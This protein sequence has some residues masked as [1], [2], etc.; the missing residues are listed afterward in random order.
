MTMTSVSTKRRCDRS[1]IER[2]VTLEMVSGAAEDG[3]RARRFRG[4][5]LDLG[6]LGIG[7]VVDEPIEP[8]LRVRITV[9]ERRD[10]YRR[11]WCWHGRS[12]YTHPWMGGYR[13]GIEFTSPEAGPGDAIRWARGDRAKL[14]RLDP[15]WSDR[16]TPSPEVKPEA[17]VAPT[18]SVR[19]SWLTGLVVTSVA[20]AADQ[21]FKA[22]S[23]SRAAG[24]L[25]RLELAPGLH[26]AP[27]APMVG[28]TA[29]GLGAIDLALA[30][31][32][33]VLLGSAT[34]GSSREAMP[35]RFA[36]LVGWSLILSGVLGNLIDRLALGYVR[37]VLRFTSFPAWS[38]NLADLLT[39]GGA[40]LLILVTLGERGRDRAVEA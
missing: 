37:D 5:L 17:R 19:P 11:V 28:S 10:G 21:V 4:R 22:W 39:I 27:R 36:D 38:F 18:R 35:R 8:G 3:S 25:A 29:A 34:R 12:V 1:R 26:L 32:T 6:R 40:A 2:G 15:P 16:D 30:L 23:A 31:G 20:L 14:V 7:L 33:L 13:V 24:G 9:E